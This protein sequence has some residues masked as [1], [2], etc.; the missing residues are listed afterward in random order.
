MYPFPTDEPLLLHNHTVVPQAFL[1]RVADIA[2]RVQ[3]LE[4][5]Y[6]AGQPSLE[7]CDKVLQIDQELRVLAS[8][9]PKAWWELDPNTLSAAHIL[10]FF[11]Q[12]FTARAHLQLALRK[13]GSNTYAYSYMVCTDACRNLASQ[14]TILRRLM[15]AGFFPVRVIDIQALTAAIFLLHSGKSRASS[16]DSEAARVPSTAA[17]VNG[18]LETMDSV[19]SS[20]GGHFAREAASAV[21][22]LRTLLESDVPQTLSLKIPLLG[23]IN[24]SRQ[25][26]KQHSTYQTAGHDARGPEAL[27][28]EGRAGALQNSQETRL[29]DAGVTDL[30]MWSMEISEVVPFL[31]DEA[32]G[33]DHWLSIGDFNVY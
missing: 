7:L 32:Y 14:Y 12:Y 31:T 24:V 33:A 29:P 22:S 10:Q 16:A 5:L 18:I 1:A 30:T 20:T 27:L 11:H 15:P 28:G 2:S 3:G 4:D 23:Q 8:M 6:D 17:L 9:P 13:D 26:A 25:A 21:R 19:S